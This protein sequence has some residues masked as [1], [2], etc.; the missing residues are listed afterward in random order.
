MSGLVHEL[1]GK[2]SLKQIIHDGDHGGDDVIA[3]LAI[4]SRPAIFDLLGITT[5]GGNIDVRIAAR[6]AL[7]ACKLAGRADVPVHIGSNISST[8]KPFPGDGAQGIDGIGGAIFP[9]P[10]KRPSTTPAVDWL[11]DTLGRSRRKVTI[12]AT[13]PL[14]NIATALDK[15]PSIS[16]SIESVVIMGGAFGNPGGNVT[17]HAEFNFAMDPDAADFVMSLIGIKRVLLPLDATQSFCFDPMLQKTVKNARLPYG[18]SIISMLRAAEKYD[19]PRFQSAGAFIHDPQV[20]FRAMSDGLYRT[21]SSG[22]RV[23]SSGG[24]ERG[25]STFVADRP[26]IDVAISCVAPEKIAKAFLDS[27]AVLAD[28]IR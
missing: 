3:T 20:V 15:E 25:K 4:L 22:V 26:P 2:C 13:G 28:G 18:A 17:P 11:I 16:S 9:M 12:F 23:R 19:M 6:N 5:C 27:L 10:D 8:G 24:D 1:R 21:I 14:T 7:I